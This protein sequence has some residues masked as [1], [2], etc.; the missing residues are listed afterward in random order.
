MQLRAGPGRQAL[1]LRLSQG[2]G[3]GA[4]GAGGG[5]GG[6]GGP[7]GARPPGGRV[8]PRALR[9]LTGAPPKPVH[10]LD[11]RWRFSFGIFFGAIFFLGRAYA[12]ISIYKKNRLSQYLGHES[13]NLPSVQV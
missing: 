1:L 13:R 10:F 4:E 3:E 2:E 7:G 8:H 5:P 6:P 9:Y 11:W 12:P